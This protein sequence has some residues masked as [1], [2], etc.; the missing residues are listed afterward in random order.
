MTLHERVIVIRVSSLPRAA[1]ACRSLPERRRSS[2]SLRSWRISKLD[3]QVAIGMPSRYGAGALGGVLSALRF[4]DS[5]HTKG[6]GHA[7]PPTISSRIARRGAGSSVSLYAR[8]G[9]RQLGEPSADRLAPGRPFPR[10][11][12]HARHADHHRLAL[13]VGGLA[14][15]DQANVTAR[16]RD[17]ATRVALDR[18]HAAA[19]RTTSVALNARAVAV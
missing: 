5:S 8:R 17:D 9:V 3:A 13:V 19:A 12:A 15:H 11:A 6:H 2:Q 4:S 14:R 7:S 1:L 16:D 10:R 18:Q